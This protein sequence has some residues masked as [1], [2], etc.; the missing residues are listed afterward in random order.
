[1]R[2]TLAAGWGR[3]VGPAGGDGGVRRTVSGMRAIEILK[4]AAGRPAEAVERLRGQITPHNLNAHIGEQDNSVAW[5]LWHIGREIDAQTAALSGQ[6]EVWASGGFAQ[7]TGL[8]KA[9]AEI[10]YGQTPEQARAVVVPDAAPLL[11]YVASASSA[12]IAYLRTLTDEDLDYVVDS[13]WDPPVTRGARIV[14][15]IDDAAQHVGQ[16]AYALG[17]L[18]DGKGAGVGGDGKGA[19]AGKKKG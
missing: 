13:S 4:D 2:P 18:G 19:S 10:G 17:A 8:G 16:A 6:S 7:R 14:S 15:I 5:L 12:L 1:M 9:G 11:E 3:R